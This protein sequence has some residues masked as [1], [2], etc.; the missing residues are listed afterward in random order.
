MRLTT[1]VPNSRRLD[2]FYLTP[3]AG[4]SKDA[5]VACI[6]K[7]RGDRAIFKSYGVP[8]LEKLAALAVRIVGAA[9][10]RQHDHLGADIDP[11]IEVGDVFIGQAQA[12]RG[13][14]GADGVRR[15]GA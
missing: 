3:Q 10:H 7:W 5:A 11:R 15:V 14:V 8:A 9:V 13:D 2:R 6:K 1:A 4:V 12:T